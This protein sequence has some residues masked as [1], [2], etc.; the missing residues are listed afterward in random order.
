MST[1]RLR[2]AARVIV[3]DGDDRVLLL[4][5]EENGGFWAVPG[6]SLEPGETHLDAAHR[7]LHEELGV[8]DMKVGP[9]LAV[10]TK[11]HPVGGE[12]ARQVEK[13]FVAVVDPETVNPAQASQPDDIR[14][15]QW[16]SLHE[17]Q[18]TAQTIY[19]LGLADLITDHLR[20]GPPATPLELAG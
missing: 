11:D 17:M 13:Y 6:G 12:T 4:R 9:E 18:E 3:L 5:Y 1:P 10:R 20:N 16:W 19:P 14:A 15:W 2:E 7:E 8:I